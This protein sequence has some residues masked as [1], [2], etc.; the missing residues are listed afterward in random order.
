MKKARLNFA[1]YF[2]LVEE[3]RVKVGRYEY[4]R[5]VDE[6]GDSHFYRYYR[7]GDVIISEEVNPV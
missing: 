7:K 4:T 3:G 1:D 6:N 5:N 2:M